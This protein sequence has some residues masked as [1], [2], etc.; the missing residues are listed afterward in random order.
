M[1][2]SHTPMS[3]WV[4]MFL[5]TPMS[6]WVYMIP[7]TLMS[8]ARVTEAA[9]THVSIPLCDTLYA[10]PYPEGSSGIQGAS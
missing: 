1:F 4:Y 9:F 3:L 8:K 2:P 5:L 6:L 7:L 10:G